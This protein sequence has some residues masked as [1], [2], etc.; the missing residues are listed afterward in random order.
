MVKVR[1]P[2]DMKNIEFELKRK[3]QDLASSLNQVFDDISTL[4]RQ[5]SSFA[6]KDFERQQQEN[7]IQE[8]KNEIER[9]HQ[10]QNLQDLCIKRLENEVI[11][12]VK[13]DKLDMKMKYRMIMKKQN[14]QAVEFQALQTRVDQD[15]NLIKEELTEKVHK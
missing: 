15:I 1:I 2:I 13:N 10:R 7:V 4:N 3:Q 11:P 8:L 5:M 6:S 14:K 12:A 9:L